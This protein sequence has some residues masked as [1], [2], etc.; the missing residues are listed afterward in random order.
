[1]ESSQSKIVLRAEVLDLPSVTLESAAES[2]CGLFF[3]ESE[4][5]AETA[6]GEKVTRFFKL[7][8]LICSRCW[9]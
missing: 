9:T 2:F 5:A 6:D 4:H 8:S 3:L 7:F 1:M